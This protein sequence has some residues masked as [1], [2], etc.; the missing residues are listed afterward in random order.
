MEQSKAC[1]LRFCKYSIYIS[2]SRIAYFKKK[3]S[4]FC[5]FLMWMHACVCSIYPCRS[6][7]DIGYALGFW[8]GRLS[9]A[10]F[11]GSCDHVKLFIWAMA[12]KLRSSWPYP[13]SGPPVLALRA[14]R[15]GLSLPTPASG[16]ENASFPAFGPPC[17]QPRVYHSFKCFFVSFDSLPECSQP[18]VQLLSWITE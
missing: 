1:S 17:L 7:K 4:R 8:L 14:T 13:L 16:L 18:P 15:R 12:S 9:R 10:G 3:K 2:S 5:F 11:T 6:Q